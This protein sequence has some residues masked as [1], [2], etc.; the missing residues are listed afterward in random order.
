MICAR[1]PSARAA[2]SGWQSIARTARRDRRTTAEDRAATFLQRRPTTCATCSPRW[3][4]RGRSAT[5]RA[6]RLD[7]RFSAL[8]GQREELRGGVVLIDDCYNANPM[9]MR[10]AI[11]DLAE[12]APGRCVAVL[13]D[14]LELGPEALLLHRE[15]GAH[16]RARGVELLVAVGAAG[17]RDAHAFDGESHAVA[18]VQRG[19]GAAS[20]TVARGRHGAREGLA[21]SRPRAAA[22]AP[23]RGDAPGAPRTR[24][25]SGRRASASRRSRA[26]WAAFSSGARPRC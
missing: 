12:T 13:G 11:D 3:P 7:V 21:R 19:S 9:S 20:G 24:P 4:P 25:T 18:D 1:S 8:R 17:G 14:M 26:E 16:A 5:P 2:R 22:R 6:G 10:A 15:I 23:S